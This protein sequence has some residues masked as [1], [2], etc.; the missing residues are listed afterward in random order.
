M[1][2]HTE[3]LRC[4]EKSLTRAEL[5]SVGPTMSAYFQPEELSYLLDQL[6]GDPHRE[7]VQSRRFRE[8]YPPFDP[9]HF[10]SPSGGERDVKMSDATEATHVPNETTLQPSMATVPEP[11][12][13]DPSPVG[14]EV[15]DEAKAQANDNTK[16][17]GLVTIAERVKLWRR[18][19][20][21]WPFPS[22]PMAEEA[23]Y[24]ASVDQ[25]EVLTEIATSCKGSMNG[26]G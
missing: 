24:A 12:D 8:V 14:A 15:T 17:P 10:A 22:A 9:V 1:V 26:D 16:Q 5:A 25:L 11:S 20:C 6:I 23:S 4:R 19:S 2:L 7:E 13:R 21:H 3:I 18:S